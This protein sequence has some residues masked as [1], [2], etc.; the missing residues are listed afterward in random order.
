MFRPKGP[1][2]S[3]T[4]EPNFGS[5]A[6]VFFMNHSAF[7]RATDLRRSCAV[8]F[9]H[10]MGAGLRGDDVFSM[11]TFGMQDSVGDSLKLLT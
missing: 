8:H 4:K 11:H 3:T 7:D 2:K 10:R 9:N 5:S 1:D 6:T